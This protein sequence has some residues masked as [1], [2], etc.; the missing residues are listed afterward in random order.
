MRL[1][2]GPTFKKKSHEKQFEFNATIMDKM[3]D[4]TSALQQTPPAVEKAKTSLAEGMASIKARQKHIRIADRSEFDWAAVEEYV[5]DELAD[6][7]D[8]EKRIQRA[9]FRAGKKLK[10][11]KGAKNKKGSASQFSKK[12]QNVGAQAG[13]VP[14]ASG[15]MS[16]LIAALL[17]TIEKM[18]GP[19]SGVQAGRSLQQLG[20]CFMCGRPG[21]LRKSCPLLL[22]TANK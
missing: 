12:A 8:D 6:G 22:G 18:P 14:S 5:E 10:S 11:A 7:E 1:E 21:H 17:P 16:Q 15:T 20:P 9:D 13:R 3:E 2:K 4:A 19:P